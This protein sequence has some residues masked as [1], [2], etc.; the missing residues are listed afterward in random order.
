MKENIFGKGLIIGIILLFIGA[1]FSPCT[2]NNTVEN[3]SQPILNKMSDNDEGLKIVR[4]RARFT[5]ESKFRIRCFHIDFLVKNVGPDIIYREQSIPTISLQANLERTRTQE[6]WHGGF[7]VLLPDIWKSQ[8]TKWEYGF[9]M[10]EE[11]EKIWKFRIPGFYTLN[12][13]ISAIG[14]TRTY[15]TTIFISMPIVFPKIVSSFDILHWNS[16]I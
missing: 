9:G 13:S 7:I 16:M 3:Q 8:E 10:S 6:R 2:A 15:N 1:T 14:I 5:T 4:I 12:V 11:Y